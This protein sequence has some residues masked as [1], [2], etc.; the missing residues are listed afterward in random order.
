[1]CDVTNAA[2]LKNEKKLV[3]AN[4]VIQGLCA[5]PHKKSKLK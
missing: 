2:D 3:W 5:K 4:P 1:M